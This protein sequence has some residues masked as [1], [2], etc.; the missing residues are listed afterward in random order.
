MADPPVLPEAVKLIVAC[1]TPAVALTPVGELGALASSGLVNMRP[2]SATQKPCRQGRTRTPG[3]IRSFRAN[4]ILKNGQGLGLIAAK[5]ALRRRRPI[6]LAAV[7]WDRAV[8]PT[9]S[10][11][12][13]E[14]PASKGAG[15]QRCFQVG[16]HHLGA[17]LP[18]KRAEPRVVRLAMAPP[19]EGTIRRCRRGELPIMVCFHVC[20]ADHLTHADSGAKPATSDK[21]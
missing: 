3:D 7:V 9:Q 2:K 1:P 19:S 5:I 11:S 6:G 13:R 20:R 17:N 8:L 12:M 14:P 21:N 15:E 10:E 18:Q 4:F 16:S